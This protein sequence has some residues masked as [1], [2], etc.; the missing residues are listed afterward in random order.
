MLAAYSST[1]SAQQQAPG[2]QKPPDTRDWWQKGLGA[3]VANPIVS[4]GLHALDVLSV[5]RR[6]IQATLWNAAEHP[7]VGGLLPMIDAEARNEDDRTWM[8]L[9][10]DPDFGFGQ[11]IDQD[12]NPWMKRLTGLTGDIALDPLT[13]FTGG[14]QKLA[15]I[16]EVAARGASAAAARSAASAAEREVATLAG[17]AAK[18]G[19]AD[20]AGLA[21]DY[22]E[23]AS[24]AATAGGEAR[25][26]EGAYSAARAA[27]GA[28]QRVD[29]HA[30]RAGRLNEL[31]NLGARQEPEWMQRNIRNIAQVAQQGYAYANPEVAE[32]LGLLPNRLR[33]AGQAV[34][35]TEYLMGPLGKTIGKV[36]G[37]LNQTRPVTWASRGSVGSEREIAELVGKQSGKGDT[38]RALAKLFFV[39]NSREGR[40]V[41]AIGKMM[42]SQYV[43]EHLAGL[44]PDELADVLRQAQRPGEMTPFN[45]LLD[46][47]LGEAQRVSGRDV[48]Q[49]FRNTTK[50]AYAPRM[51]TTEWRRMVNEGIPGAQSFKDK[52]GLATNDLLE[53]S[54]FVEHARKFKPGGTYEINGRSITLGDASIDDLNVKLGEAFPELGPGFKFYEDNPIKLAESYIDSVARQTGRD[55]AVQRL[56]ESKYPFAVGVEGEVEAERAAMAEALQH[57]DPVYDAMRMGYTDDAVRHA[58]TGERDVIPESQYFKPGKGEAAT[59]ERQGWLAG[60]EAKQALAGLREETRN[61]IGSLVELL[62][63]ERNQI[64]GDLATVGAGKVD[65]TAMSQKVQALRREIAKLVENKATASSTITEA[66]RMMDGEIAA[67]EKQLARENR[68]LGRRLTAAEE[69]ARKLLKDT[70]E[71]YRG[72]SR[73]LQKRLLDDP[74]AAEAYAREAASLR[75]MQ[76]AEQNLARV[77]ERFP[78]HGLNEIEANRV[79]EE[80]GTGRRVDLGEGRVRYTREPTFEEQQRIAR[81]TTEPQRVA[82]LQSSAIPP[83]AKAAHVLQADAERQAFLSANPEPPTMPDWLVGQRRPGAQNEYADRAGEWVISKD[84]ETKRWVV[85][86]RTGDVP[87]PTDVVQPMTEAEQQAQALVDQAAAQR[88]E[89]TPPAPPAIPK[90]DLDRAKRIL[91]EKAKRDEAALAS[92]AREAGEQMELLPE[93]HPSLRAARQWVND[94]VAGDIDA[95]N[96]MARQVYPTEEVNWARATTTRRRPTPEQVAAAE[97]SAAAAKAAKPDL[98]EIRQQRSP[99]QGEADIAEALGR[100]QPTTEEREWAARVIEEQDIARQQARREHYAAEEARQRPPAPDPTLRGAKRT[101]HRIEGK[102]RAWISNDG[103]FTIRGTLQGGEEAG[104]GKVTWTLTDAAGKVKPRQFATSDQ[105]L[106]SLKKIRFAEIDETFPLPNLAR[107]P[108]FNPRPNEAPLPRLPYTTQEEDLARRIRDIPEVSGEDVRRARHRAQFTRRAERTGEMSRAEAIKT[109]M[110]ATKLR[111][112]RDAALRVARRR[113]EIARNAARDIPARRQIGEYA[114][115]EGESESSYVA[116]VIEGV[117]AE[118]ASLEQRLATAQQRLVGLVENA[119][120]FVDSR[121]RRVREGLEREIN[122]LSEQL[123]E[124]TNARELLYRRGEGTAADYEGRIAVKEGVTEVNQAELDRLKTINERARGAERKGKAFKKATRGRKPADVDAIQKQYVKPM[125]KLLEANAAAKEGLAPLSDDI[126]ERTR[127]VLTAG[128][129]RAESILGRQ[130]IEKKSEQLIRLARDGKLPPVEVPITNDEWRLLGGGLPGQGD[131]LFDRQLAERIQ[132]L[133]ELNKEPKLFGRVFNAFTNLFK[134]YSTL[135]PG[136][137][138]RNALGGI[139]MNTADGVSLRNQLRGAILWRRY[140]KEGRA[141]LDTLSPSEREAFRVAFSSGAGGRFAEAGVVSGATPFKSEG[142]LEHA[143]QRAMNNKATRLGQRAGER[144]EGSLRLGMA[145]DSIGS[146]QSVQEALTRVNRVHF[147][148]SDVSKLDENA[149]RLIPFWTFMSRNLPLQVS[150]MWTKPRAYAIYESIKR[151]LSS[152]D[153]PFTPNYWKQQG[154]WNTGLKLGGLPMYLNPD[155]GYQQLQEQVNEVESALQ[156]SPGKV[157]SEMNPMFTAPAEFIARKDFYTGQEFPENENFVQPSGLLGGALSGVAGLLHQANAQGQVDPAFINL[158]RGTNPVLDRIMRMAPGVLSA[159]TGQGTSKRQA[160]S[161]LRFLG[162]PIRTLTPEQQRSE[163]YRRYYE[164]IDKARQYQQMMA[165]AAAS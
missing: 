8:E 145:L 98:T 76:D 80:Y 164:Q 90:K 157:L 32:A 113:L 73:T 162:A 142:G 10:R 125:E 100:R 59:I 99:N 24:R 150:E 29:V 120:E 140:M 126:V 63:G 38:Y 165:T 88:A 81:A 103:R 130:D 9:V 106:A 74:V 87:V 42:L 66:L 161:I 112:D 50:D 146:G 49:F 75:P 17:R 82:A 34:P 118:R 77:E 91:R 36:K 22:L 105:A 37:G 65:I 121:V 116:R 48:R 136:F 138:V 71:S 20:L 44:G 127:G 122:D 153:E 101:W 123:G 78:P 30:N 85:R 147:D 35:G 124:K 3:V 107:P 26:A 60:G 47:V 64:L 19:T 1:Q 25:A 72:F 128:Q 21:D 54:S 31:M 33:F 62:K 143:Y 151:N 84:P 14:Q 95:Y 83:D 102:E 57:Q 94:K 23:A 110:A 40:E 159:E 152:E 137:Q 96:Q 7:V 115:R 41:E 4:T 45:Q 53:G 39:N 141:F 69:Q 160:E 79:S 27:P 133:Y 16:P 158:L 139:F 108:G 111:K 131:T 119:P 114:I 163:A 52:A 154:A 93:Q 15:E 6:A 104:S 135:S 28:M 70:I 132:R 155:L 46:D 148:Y 2:Y 56:R 109:R 43:R 129:K 18:A 89:T 13:Y 86:H 149:K 55:V 51:L 61:R 92:A 68:N 5:P 67:L 58:Q 156:G 144:V 117:K 12:A 97:E 134:T 11:M